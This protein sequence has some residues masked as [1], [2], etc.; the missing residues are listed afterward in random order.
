MEYLRI[1]QVAKKLGV[2][3]KK[4]YYWRG[5]GL[6]DAEVKLG[7]ICVSLREFKRLRTIVIQNRKR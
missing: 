1:S 4:V 7:M 2:D 3:R 5:L 6:F